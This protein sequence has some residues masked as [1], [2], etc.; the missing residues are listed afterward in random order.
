[1]TKSALDINDSFGTGTTNQ[2]TTRLWFQQFWG[3]DESFQVVEYSGQPSN[4]DNKQLRALDE[5]NSHFTDRKLT[6]ELDVT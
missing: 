3:E 4:V 1:M 5:T 6:N 2:R